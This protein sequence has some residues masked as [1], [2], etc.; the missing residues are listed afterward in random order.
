[1]GWKLHKNIVA[2]SL[3]WTVTDTSLSPDKRFLVSFFSFF[4]FLILF[5]KVIHIQFKQWSEVFVFYILLFYKF[6]YHIVH[7]RFIQ[8]CLLLSTLLILDLLEQI[9]MQMSRYEWMLFLF[10]SVLMFVC[11]TLTMGLTNLSE[12]T[13]E[14]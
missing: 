8:L 10:R 13:N 2:E 9:L 3:R 12:H 14:H 1:M 6:T 7:C 5:L 11:L 4:S